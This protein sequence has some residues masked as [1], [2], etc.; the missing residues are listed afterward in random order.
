MFVNRVCATSIAIQMKYCVMWS[1]I[2]V[3]D[4]EKYMDSGTGH[5]HEKRASTH[6]KYFIFEFVFYF[7]SKIEMIC[8]AGHIDYIKYSTAAHDHTDTFIDDMATK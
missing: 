7:V 2:T 3:F 6:P 4:N 1:N 5:R 8:I